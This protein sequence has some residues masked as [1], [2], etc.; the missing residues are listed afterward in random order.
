LSTGTSIGVINTAGSYT[1]T[2][3]CAWAGGSGPGSFVIISVTSA[4]PPAASI[5]TFTA[6][7]DSIVVGQSTAFAWSSANATSCT[8]SGGT[9]PPRGQI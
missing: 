3:T 4:P 7:P 6:S 2:L 9:G 1:Y 5:S 8:A